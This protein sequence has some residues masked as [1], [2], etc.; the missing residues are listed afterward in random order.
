MGTGKGSRK[1]LLALVKSG[2]SVLELKNCRGGLLLKASKY[3]GVRCTFN[4]Q[5]ISAIYGSISKRGLAVHNY[6]IKYKKLKRI[7]LNYVKDRMDEIYITYS[8]SSN[9]KRLKKVFQYL[10]NYNSV[11]SAYSYKVKPFDKN[12]NYKLVYDSEERFLDT[13]N[14]FLKSNIKLLSYNLSNKKH[15]RFYTILK[16]K[17]SIYLKRFR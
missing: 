4:T 5:A 12:F 9:I 17:K 8:S 16:L 15:S 10:N 1:G 7:P 2:N 11:W 3:L 13:Y 6:N 14:Y